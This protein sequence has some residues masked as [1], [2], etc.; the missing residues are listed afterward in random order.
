MYVRNLTTLFNLVMPTVIPTKVG[1]F[2]LSCHKRV[3]CLVK[4]VTIAFTGAH[5]KIV[6]QNSCLLVTIRCIIFDTVGIKV[7]NTLRSTP[8]SCSG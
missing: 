3:K 6:K 5:E 4:S 2:T 8:D 7:L 1:I